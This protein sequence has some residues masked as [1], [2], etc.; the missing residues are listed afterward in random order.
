[1]HTFVPFLKYEEK[2]G[3]FKVTSLIELGVI[4]T[5]LSKYLFP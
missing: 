3:D 4:I 2:L 5:Y 1:M